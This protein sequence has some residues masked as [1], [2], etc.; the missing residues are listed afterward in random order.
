MLVHSSGFFG[1]KPATMT[2]QERL[3]KNALCDL[4]MKEG[5]NGRQ[6]RFCPWLARGS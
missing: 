5:I 6:D 1:R 4:P 3:H 2:D